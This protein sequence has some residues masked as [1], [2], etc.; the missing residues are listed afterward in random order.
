MIFF[1]TNV[2]AYQFDDASPAK[3]KLAR[4]LLLAH[5]T[6]V[7]VSTQVLIELHSVLTRKLGR[8]R[9][10]ALQVIRT[11][12]VEVVSTDAGLV[13]DA[14]ETAASHGL[15]IFDALVIEAAARARCVQLWTEDLQAGSTLRGVRVVNPFACGQEA[16]SS[17]GCPLPVVS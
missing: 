2:L 15:S 12:D 17:N 4:E 1:D 10:E 5:A 8:T 11:L 14:A 7:V 6:E 9:D 3:Q 13:R 16:A